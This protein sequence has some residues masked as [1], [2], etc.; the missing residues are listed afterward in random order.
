MVLIVLFSFILLSILADVLIQY[1]QKKK[2]VHTVLDSD[3]TYAFQES[4]V[5]L[6]KGLFFDRSHTWA[7][8]EKNGKVK[9]G[10]NDFLQHVTGPITSVSMK[11]AGEEIKR[12]EEL[13]KIS[14]Q[15]KQ[16]SIYSPVSGTIKKQNFDL[17]KDSTKINTSPY[18]DGWLY[19][20]EPGNWLKETQLM[21]MAEKA[22]DWLKTEFI[23]LKDF[24]ALYTKQETP[25]FAPVLQDGGSIREGALAEMGPKIWEDFQTH[26]ID[27]TE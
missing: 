12:G 25:G 27:K 16:L 17:L 18:N 21:K 4:S 11:E 1:Y 26:F 2:T 8:M 7:F 3:K 9:I 19:M 15:G 5:I 20:I 13:V 22:S 6:P 10:I 14:R 24:F 23:R